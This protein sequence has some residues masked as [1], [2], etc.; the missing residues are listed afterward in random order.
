MQSVVSHLPNKGKTYQLF[1]KDRPNGKDKYFRADAVTSASVKVDGQNTAIMLN[2]DGKYDFMVRLEIKDSSHNKPKVLDKDNG[3]LETVDDRPCWVVNITLNNGQG[4]DHDTLYKWYCFHLD[5]KGLPFRNHIVGYIALP[6][7]STYKYIQDVVYRDSDKNITHINCALLDSTLTPA[8]KIHMTGHKI[9]ITEFMTDKKFIT[10]ELMAGDSLCKQKY[11]LPNETLPF[12][13][14]HGAIPV[15]D[16]M[17]P[18]ELSYDGFDTWFKSGKADDEKYN[19]YADQEGIVFR[20]DEKFFK[21][22]HGSCVEKGKTIGDERMWN[23]KK[24]CGL[25]FDVSNILKE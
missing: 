17:F 1:D 20:Q 22:R 23:S 16:D 15:P 18:K 13:I 4:V 5:E 2:K 19:C 10:C 21:V 8:G 12:V 24:G 9:S 7:T 11:A 14:I 3:K 25:V 6:E